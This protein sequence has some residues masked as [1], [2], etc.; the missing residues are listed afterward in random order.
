[1]ALRTRRGLGRAEQH[2]LLD[3]D[4]KLILPGATVD[5]TAL[6]L[7]QI[8]GLFRKR[9]KRGEERAG[10]VGETHG[11]GN[12]AG[13]G[14]K[15]CS[16]FVFREQEHEAGEILGVVLDAFS[17]DHALVVLGGSAPSDGGGRLVPREQALRGRCR[18][19]LRREYASAPDGGKKAFA[20]REGHGCEATE[21]RPASVAPGTPIRW[22][23]DGRM[24]FLD[25]VRRL[26]RSR[27]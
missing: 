18:P 5:G 21:R 14:R 24:G 11:E 9:L 4:E 1:V 17:K 27:S 12:L 20:L 7:E 15:P 10:A 26:W 2:H 16:R 19:C 8:Y 22:W 6:D 3:I 25:H 13:V 23:F